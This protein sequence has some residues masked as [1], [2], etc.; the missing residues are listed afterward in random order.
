MFLFFREIG[1]KNRQCLIKYHP[2]M[3]FI[4][5]FSNSPRRQRVR[6]TPW[7]MHGLNETQH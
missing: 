5:L 3:I 2:Q 1:I 4:F 6:K 7:A